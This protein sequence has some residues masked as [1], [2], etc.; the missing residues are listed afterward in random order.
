[1]ANEKSLGGSQKGG[2]GVGSQLGKGLGSAMSS[3]TPPGTPPGPGPALE[4]RQRLAERANSLSGRLTQVRSSATL[5]DL[6]GSLGRLDALL[7]NLPAALEELRKGGYLYKGYLEKKIEVL[8][9]QW[10][11][12]RA[13]VDSE[14]MQQGRMLS[15]EA[16]Q[17]QQRLSAMGGNLVAAALDAL[18]R[19]IVALEGKV[20]SAANT[21]QRLYDTI[22]QNGRQTDQQIK[23]AKQLLQHIAAATF[24]L[25][26][27][28]NPVEEVEAQYLV[29]GDNGPKGYLFLT[30]QRLIFEQNE[31]VATKKFLF[32]TTA[33]ERVQK[34]L[35]EVPIGGVTQ[36]RPS[37]KGALMFKKEILELEVSG[38]DIARATL[39]LDADSEDWAALIGRV[40]SGDIATEKVGAG[41]A[42]AEVQATPANVPT[43][44]PTCAAQLPE[45]MRGETSLKCQYCGTIVRV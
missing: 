20:Q 29:D 45:L 23:S 41:A 21:L 11:G 1:M 8:R 26:Q 30:D 36:A 12:L 43:K 3:Q 13:R 38:A 17:L 31:N 14:A 18:E 5:G 9:E 25:R 44:C 39:K 24:R 10:Q 37:E 22:E 6:R 15:M 19:D 32:I 7:N 34:T 40:R 4:E 33:S 35:W 2:S 42:A 27:G 16:D 28:E